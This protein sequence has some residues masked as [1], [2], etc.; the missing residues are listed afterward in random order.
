MSVPYPAFTTQVTYI[1]AI[2]K[3][4]NLIIISITIITIFNSTT[5]LHSETSI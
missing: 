4:R 3:S 5:Q 2:S 1:N